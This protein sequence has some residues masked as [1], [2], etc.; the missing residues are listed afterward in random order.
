MIPN[1]RRIFKGVL[2]NPLA[3]TWMELGMGDIDWG[4]ICLGW[5]I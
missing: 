5:K 1:Q 3:T 2:G 4:W